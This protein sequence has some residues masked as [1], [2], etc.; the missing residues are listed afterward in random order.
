VAENEKLKSRS[1]FALCLHYD[2]NIH[3][4]YF[5]TL[6]LESK[7][8]EAPLKSCMDLLGLR[9]RSPTPSPNNLP[10]T[11]FIAHRFDEAGQDVADKVARFLSLLGFDCQ[12]G[13]GYAPRSVA[14]KVKERLAGQAVV[15]A[16]MTP[17]D[18][19]TWL[20]QESL[21]GSITGKPLMILKESKAEFKA[22]IL[23]DHEYIP[24]TGRHVEQTFIPLLE[25]LRE[26]KYKFRE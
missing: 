5:L 11:A 3:G 6:D 25:G 7:S 8:P 20:T 4:E 22:G 26:L 12:T 23:S 18:D 21:L 13:R 17:G 15:V 14:E 1:S 9:P 16:I 10:R 24:F 19:A 2:W